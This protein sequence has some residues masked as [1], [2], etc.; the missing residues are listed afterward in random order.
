M[1]TLSPDLG[2]QTLKEAS[3]EPV[4]TLLPAAKIQRALFMLAHKQ[5]LMQRYTCLCESVMVFLSTVDAMEFFQASLKQS[6]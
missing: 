5:K 2:F 3:A 4:Q 1:W 6:L